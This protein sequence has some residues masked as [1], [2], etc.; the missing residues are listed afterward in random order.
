MTYPIYKQEFV[1]VIGGRLLYIY[2]NYIEL[3][4]RKCQDTLWFVY[5][6]QADNSV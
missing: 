4:Y 1:S 6:L 2:S 5:V 3:G